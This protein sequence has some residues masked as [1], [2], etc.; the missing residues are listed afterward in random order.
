[1][2]QRS[3]LVGTPP[4]IADIRFM[5][6]VFEPSNALEGYMLQDL[7][8]QRGISSRVDGAQ[9]QGG[10]GEIPVTGFV[11]LV[12]AD[13]D[14][15][16]ARAV[17]EEWES[18]VLPDP[19]PIPTN[20]PAIGM[21]GALIGLV[22]GI[23]GSYVFFRVPLSTDGIDHNEDGRLDERWLSSPAGS[24]LKTE[25]DRNFDDKVDYVFNFDRRGH[26][27]SADA[28]EDFDG[29]F[30]TR[31]RYYQ[32]NAEIGKTDTDGDSLIDLKF[33]SKHGVLVST[34]Y[35]A[36]ESA[37]P[38]RIDYFQLGRITTTEIDTDRDGQMDTRRKYSDLAEVIATE[39]I[40]E[41]E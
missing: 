29:I 7:L 25:L 13:K 4:L 34:E 12:V 31:W 10:V 8:Q 14:Y 37:Q 32:G 24:P 17:V 3:S 1:V 22:L 35:F 5:K 33:K 39:A 30:E 18:T 11:R 19:T 26:V 6:T 23:A 36:P 20:R 9:L 41:P 2:V 15:E 38:V 21:R 27:A 28:D 16:S 40:G